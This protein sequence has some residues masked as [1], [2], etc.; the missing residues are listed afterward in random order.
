MKRQKNMAFVK[1]LL[2]TGTC[3]YAILKS[4][5]LL[6]PEIEDREKEGK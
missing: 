2:V 1:L 4:G 6:R 3:K 5:I